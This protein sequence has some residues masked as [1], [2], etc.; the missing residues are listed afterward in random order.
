MDSWGQQPFMRQALNNTV[1]EH[2]IDDGLNL[3]DSDHV[4]TIQLT[5]PCINNTGAVTANSIVH[6]VF[7]LFERNLSIS[8]DGIQFY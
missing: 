5:T 6:C 1:E 8:V 4:Y 7:A 2:Q 3:L